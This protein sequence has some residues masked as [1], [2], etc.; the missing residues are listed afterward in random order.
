M[1][2]TNSHAKYLAHELTK[3]CSSDAELDKPIP[4]EAAVLLLSSAVRLLRHTDLLDRLGNGLAAP[5]LDFDL[6]QLGMICSASSLFPRGIECPS[7]AVT[8]PDYLSGS[9]AV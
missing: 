6:S 1:K 9:G 2:T 7:L 5:H 8:P 3:R 4:R